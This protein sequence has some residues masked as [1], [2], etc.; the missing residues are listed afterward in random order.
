VTIL[1]VC[2]NNKGK[3]TAQHAAEMQEELAASDVLKPD[4][5]VS[6]VFPMVVPPFTQRVRFVVRDAA[7]GA[8]GAA[9]ANP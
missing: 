8:I 5:Q 2:Y 1:A 9:N 7:T 6:F 3:E 4:S